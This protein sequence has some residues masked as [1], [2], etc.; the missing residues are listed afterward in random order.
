MKCSVK[1]VL[2]NFVASCLLLTSSYTVPVVQAQTSTFNLTD[3]KNVFV[4]LFENH[5]WSQ[6]KGS[7]E[8]P[9]INNTLLPSGAHA[10]QYY[11]PPGLHPSEPNYLWL[12][13]GTNFGV[14]NDK[15]PS[16]NHQ[17]TTA[18]LVTLLNNAGISWKSYQ[19]DIPGNVC[20][21]TNVNLYAPKHNPMVYFDDVTGNNDPS[22]PY[23][24]AHVRPYSELST[25]LQNNT[26]ASYNFI[27]PNLCNDM[28]NCD[29]SA[30]D[31]WLAS[32]L[33][34]ILN[35][36]AYK[37]G[38][39]IFITFD[40]SEGG[41]FPIGMIVLS[42]FVRVPG[43]SNAIHYTHSSTLRTVQEIFGITPLLR[44]AANA[45]DL[46]DLFT[47]TPPALSSL[48]L[49]PNA[50]AAPCQTS[51]G[52]VTLSAPALT[53]GV[54]VTLSNTNGAAVVPSSVTVP[55]GTTSATFTITTSPTAIKKTGT[56]TASYDGMSFTKTLT[57]RPVGVKSLALSPNPV[58]GPG[59]VTGTVKL[60]CPATAG[61][62]VV[63][64]SSN[65]PGVAKPSV[66]SINI[67]QGSTTGTF[68]ITT[69]NVTATS[70]ATI[71]AKANG[72][73]KSVKLTV[74]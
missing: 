8:A 41:D 10:E 65:A 34:K 53:G 47:P 25:D 50:I 67:P 54:I 68:P 19:E 17:S 31:A 37:D 49:S 74:E 14:K 66:A 5:N 60:S 33:P 22:N 70:S 11:N 9:Y 56:V 12:E 36:Q 29:V 1:L 43:Y 23:C 2:V 62:V 26:V 18:H 51:K 48:T 46:I 69:V 7:P 55:E 28:H 73:A 59:G 72:I 44:D 63:A 32:E 64:L 3:V 30:G 21:L 61:G 58:T 15:L 24:I 52:R 13:A 4:I 39:A 35:S 40:E 20:P 38:G 57:V 27:T 16:V 71:T 45:T 42:P 6:I